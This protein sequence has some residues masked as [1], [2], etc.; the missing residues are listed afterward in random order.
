MQFNL[1]PKPSNSMVQFTLT[2]T[3]EIREICNHVVNS[4]IAH[5]PQFNLGLIHT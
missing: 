1:T 2:F 3:P 4:V 5:K